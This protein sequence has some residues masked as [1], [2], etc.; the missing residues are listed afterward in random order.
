MLSCREAVSRLG[1]FG[2]GELAGGKKRETARHLAR[3]ASCL[4]YWRS[5]RT[6]IA[7]A[8]RAF[9]EGNPRDLSLPEGLARRILD[10]ARFRARSKPVFYVVHLLSGIAAAPLLAFWL[11]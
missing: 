3:C 10:A 5:Y 7:L 6:T 9:S 8:R 11:R 4:S 2:A 1:D